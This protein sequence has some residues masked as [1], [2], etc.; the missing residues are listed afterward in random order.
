MVALGAA[1]AIDTTRHLADGQRQAVGHLEVF[2]EQAY[3]QHSSEHA[4]SGQL[5]SNVQQQIQ[6]ARAISAQALHRSEA[7]VG[8]HELLRQVRTAAQS[9]QAAVDQKM[10][11]L[12][13]GQ[14]TAA[15][16]LDQRRLEPSFKALLEVIERAA[17]HFDDIRRRYALRREFGAYR[18][19]CA[20]LPPDTV[21]ELT[22]LGFQCT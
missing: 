7:I 15:R 6:D 3:R 11:L 16:K 9:Y 22:A 1:V 17:T 21:A 18:V 4:S 5:P 13:N 8:R 12:T 20:G 19:A 10:L 14:F 2:K